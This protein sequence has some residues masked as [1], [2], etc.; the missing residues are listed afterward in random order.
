MPEKIDR[1]RP[2]DRIQA[3]SIATAAASSAMPP[4]APA[5]SSGN[6]FV[7]VPICGAAALAAR[8]A[9]TAARPAATATRPPVL[10]GE[11]VMPG[12]QPATAAAQVG[13]QQRQRGS[14]DESRGRAD[15]AV[16]LGDRVAV[17]GRGRGG[18]EDLDG[19][20]VGSSSSRWCIAAARALAL[21]CAT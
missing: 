2:T 16:P 10:L 4:A 12:R 19:R 9:R 8:T 13:H 14:Q 5:A 15:H 11:R 7:D 1:A 21:S 18:V 6:A 20:P 3:G 17:A